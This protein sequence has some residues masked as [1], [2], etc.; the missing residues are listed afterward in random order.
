[1]LPEGVTAQK[2][3]SGIRLNQRIG[4]ACIYGA[5]FMGTGAILAH[6]GPGCALPK[7][8]QKLYTKLTR[9]VSIG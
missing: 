2:P 8:L 7:K 3:K 6:A 9:L 5:L 4:F 1:M